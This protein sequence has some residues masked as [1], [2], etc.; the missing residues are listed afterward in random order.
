[1]NHSDLIPFAYQLILTTADLAGQVHAMPEAPAGTISKY[2]FYMFSSN[3]TGGTPKVVRHAVRDWGPH[4]RQALLVAARDHATSEK[5]KAVTA[6][7]R[8][9]GDEFKHAVVIDAHYRKSTISLEFPYRLDG[10]AVI[11]DPPLDSMKVP[12]SSALA[13]WSKQTKPRFLGLF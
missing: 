7:V 13:D 6:V 3:Q 5:G 2:S 12:L 9:Y 8:S 10:S 1:M 4:Q 11:F